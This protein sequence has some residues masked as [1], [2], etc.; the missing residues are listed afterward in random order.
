MELRIRPIGFPAMPVLAT[1]SKVKSD[2]PHIVFDGL[3][4]AKL[5]SCCTLNP[6]SFSTP[7]LSHMMTTPWI[8]P[9]IAR[10]LVAVCSLERSFVQPTAA[11][12]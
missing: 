4:L 5:Q 9:T 6:K 3:S 10:T 2:N 1:V 7:I 8:P 12:L 11:E